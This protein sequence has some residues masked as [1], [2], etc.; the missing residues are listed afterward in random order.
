MHSSALG[1]TGKTIAARIMPDSNLVEEIIAICEENQLEAAY[2][3]TCIGSLKQGRFVYAIPDDSTYFKM[4]YSDPFDLE[5][6][7]EFL[8]A[9]GIVAKGE[10]GEY[11]VHLHA[12]LSDADMRVYGGHVV[13]TGNIVLATVDLVLN[14]IKDINLARKYHKESGFFFFTPEE[15]DKGGEN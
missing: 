15:A 2:I 12:T 7:I 10:N 13:E 4:R 8:G 5:G 6:P 11:L 14:E 9:Q 1:T 3:P